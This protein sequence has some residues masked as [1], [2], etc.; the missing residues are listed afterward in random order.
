MKIHES[1]KINGNPRNTLEVPRGQ[2]ASLESSKGFHKG[3]KSSHTG[4]STHVP[5]F[6]KIYEN[7]TGYIKINEMHEIRWK[8]TEDK[9]PTWNRAKVSKRVAGRFIP[10]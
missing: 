9:K 7:P 2:E 5:K 3:R 8:S 10:M 6:M 1:I 4:A